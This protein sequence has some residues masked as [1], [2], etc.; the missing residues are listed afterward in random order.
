MKGSCSILQHQSRHLKAEKA[1]QLVCQHVYVCHCR[2][3]STGRCYDAA[4]LCHNRGRGR[5]P[6][7]PAQHWLADGLHCYSARSAH[8]CHPSGGLCSSWTTYAGQAHSTSTHLCNQ[9]THLQRR[10]A[11]LLSVSASYGFSPE[12][13]KSLAKRHLPVIYPYVCKTT[14]AECSVVLQPITR[15]LRTMGVHLSCMIGFT[16]NQSAQ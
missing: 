1:S 5:L 10:A 14:A 2:G 8:G 15:L 7:S 9:S 16:R 11:C 4:L 3:R 6:Y 13:L 12:D